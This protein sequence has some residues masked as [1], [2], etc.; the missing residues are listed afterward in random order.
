MADSRDK[1]ELE[2]LSYEPVSAPPAVEGKNTPVIR[3]ET[4]ANNAED[5]GQHLQESLCR[6]SEPEQPKDGCKHCGA[7][8]MVRPTGEWQFNCRCYEDDKLYPLLE[9]PNQNLM[10]IEEI[11]GLLSQANDKMYELP[12]HPVRSKAIEEIDL[13][14]KVTVKIELRKAFE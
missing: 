6:E 1:P 9:Q 10:I 3:P 12:I 14:N 5:A 4:R 11:E 8:R 7:C 2:T 13:L